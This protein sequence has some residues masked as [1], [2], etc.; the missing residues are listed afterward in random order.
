MKC[1]ECSH[2]QRVSDGMTC[3]GCGYGFTFNPRDTSFH[4]MTDG[5]FL[6]HIR[7]ASRNETTYFT[8]NQLY[9]AY[10]RRRRPERMG[11]FVLAGILTTVIITQIVN[12]GPWPLALLFLVPL[13]LV[14][15]GL[16]VKPAVVSP[17]QFSAAIG[18]WLK[19]GKKIDYLL[20]VPSLHK[21]PP[22]WSEPDIYDYGVERLLIVERDLLVDLFVRNNKHAEQRMLVVSESGYPDYLLPQARRLLVESPDLSVFLLHDATTDGMRMEERLRRSEIL[23]LAGRNVIDLGLSP[24]DFRKLKRTANYDRKNSER[25]LPADALPLAFLAT[26]LAASFASNISLGEQLLRDAQNQASAGS[27]FG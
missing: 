11:C 26:G 4:G 14:A 18:R 23:P 19:A 15:M 24:D 5:K 12:L 2:N 1:P 20:D 16:R 6:G 8:E 27:S 3:G 9:A 17:Q 21:P 7:A 13:F 25:A 22:D 10:A